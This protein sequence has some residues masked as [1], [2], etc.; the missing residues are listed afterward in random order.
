[1][2]MHD[3]LLLPTTAMLVSLLAIAGALVATVHGTTG[4]SFWLSHAALAVAGSGGGVY[5][6]TAFRRNRR[7]TV[8]R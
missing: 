8:R 7:L 2:A 1:M 3:I 4:P 6:A 5:V